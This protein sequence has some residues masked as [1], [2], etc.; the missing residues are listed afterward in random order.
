MKFLVISDTHRDVS[1]AVNIID[2][3]SSVIDGVIHCGDL[4][5]DAKY[6]E[7]K[8][9]E[10]GLEFHYVRGNCDFTNSAELEKV[11]ELDGYRVM[12]THGHIQDVNFTLSKLAY[13]GMELGAD[14]VLFGHTH[15][16]VVEEYNDMIIM[17]PGS[18]TRPRGGSKSNYGILKIDDDGVRV[19]LLEYR[20]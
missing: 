18:L 6:L 5:E 12:I 8:Y 17:N 13:R 10:S 15:I 16:P 4:A 7:H 2:S 9:R 19:S 3:I 11:V 20:E 14:V 1:R